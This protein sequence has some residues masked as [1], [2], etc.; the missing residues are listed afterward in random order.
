LLKVK[1]KGVPFTWV[2]LE[3]GPSLY[4]ENYILKIRL[5]I[6]EGAVASGMAVFCG[7]QRKI[8]GVDENCHAAVTQKT[9]EIRPFLYI[10]INVMII[11]YCC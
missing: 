7:L 11:T 4:S 9:P 8:S 10:F 6:I 1:L 2:K 3:E 5:L